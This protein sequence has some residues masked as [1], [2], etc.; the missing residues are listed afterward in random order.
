VKS[1]EVSRIS[2]S[3]E[4]NEGWCLCLAGATEEGR[5]RL[6]VSRR[7]LRELTGEA[8]HKAQESSDDEAPHDD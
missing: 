8:R 5:R 2:H 4:R 3:A 6:E 7:Q 1:H